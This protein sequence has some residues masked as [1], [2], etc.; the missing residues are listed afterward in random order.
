M[1][2]KAFKLGFEDQGDPEQ[3]RMGM[4]AR[5]GMRGEWVGQSRVHLICQSNRS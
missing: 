5:T 3:M 4:R 1:E 2:E